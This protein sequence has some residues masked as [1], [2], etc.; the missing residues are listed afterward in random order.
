[1]T[2]GRIGNVFNQRMRISAAVGVG[3]VQVFVRSQ[4][5]EFQLFGEIRTMRWLLCHRQHCMEIHNDSAC[6]T[7]AASML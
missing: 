2:M 3:S 5:Y 7:A 6:V 1:M 4:T